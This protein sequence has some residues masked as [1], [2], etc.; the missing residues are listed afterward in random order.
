MSDWDES[1]DVIVVGS[2]I[3]GLSAAAT[4]ASKGCRVLVFEKSREIGGTSVL[5]SGEYWVP[6]NRWLRGAGIEDPR[7]DCL[8]YMAR[9]SYP[10][11]YDPESETLGVPRNEFELLEAYYDRGSEAVD[12]L[13]ELEAVKSRFS[14][15]FD[16]VMGKPEYN[17]HIP[18]NRV[19]FGRHL[20]SEGGIHTSG[21][22]TFLI[23]GLR[24]YLEKTDT[25][26]RHSH[27]VTSIVQDETGRV[28]GVCV[29]GPDGKSL[30]IGARRG[31]VFGTGGFSHDPELRDRYLRG[32]LYGSTAVETNTG[33]FLRIG[34]EVG[35]SVGNLEM[36]WWGQTPLEF[37]LEEEGRIPGMSYFPWG[38]SMIMVN[39]EG[40]RIV[41]EKAP[42]HDRAQA[43]F[44]F[45][46]TTKRY[47]NQVM[48]QVYDRYVAETVE[49]EGWHKVRAPI[50]P[51]GE[52]PDYLI[53][54][55]TLDE[56]SEEIRKRLEALKR[57]TGGLELSPGFSTTL[58]ST[59][60]RFNQFALE[61]KDLDFGRGETPHELNYSPPIREGL[62]NQ[63]MA[64]FEPEGPYCAILLV[65][66]CFDTCGGPRID[67]EARV[68][69][70][71]DRPIPG[72]YAA[73]N[74]VA[75]PVGQ[76]YWSGGVTIGSGLIFGYV[77]GLN[78]A[79]NSPVD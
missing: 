68:I 72:L 28:T 8:K 25:E 20:L 6:N 14:P 3:A 35:A 51:V 18:E 60:E 17:A 39:V 32:K 65:A 77:G 76:A 64:P 50:P 63:T 1:A 4:A 49:P 78:A 62:K 7:E 26:I 66:A 5:S 31:V 48:I 59:V 57:Q 38:D 56:L 2:G 74:C 36:A 70:A 21:Q 34:M 71:E 12:Y 16:L 42:Y 53:I 73:G 67:R 46:P 40:E 43:H 75:S 10:G 79:G 37:A 33:D 41:N 61:G 30:K 9:L 44:Y 54:G 23:G 15:D 19:T 45:N 24:D 13:D 29:E 58:K 22:G 27:A 52:F 47:T 11:L 69:D 55:E